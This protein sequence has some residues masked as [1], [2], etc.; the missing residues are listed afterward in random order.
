MN[1]LRT[2][3]KKKGIGQVELAG[4][5]G[6]GQSSLSRYESGQSDIPT[7][8]LTKMA[9]IFEVS[10]DNILGLDGEP[11]PFGRAIEIQPELFP[12]D[13]VLIPVM[14]SLRCGFNSAGEPCVFKD[15]K[16]VPVS[17]VRRWGKNIV[18][19]EAVGDSMVPTV[20]PG[21]LCICVPGSAWESGNIVVVNINDSDTIKRIKRT[22]DGGVDL[23]PDNEEY[24]TM[25]LT[26][27]DISRFQVRVL[28]RIVKVI[29]PDL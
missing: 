7:D 6:I 15:R 9:E 24:D 21:D 19:V 27:D 16:P 22:K 10:T 14:V 3:R 25:H 28:G 26:P 8:I 5:L 18:Y 12:E 4:M 29:G 1:N 2:L 13:E 11:E 20:T 23:I 17:W